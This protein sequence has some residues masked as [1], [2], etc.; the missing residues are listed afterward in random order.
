MEMEPDIDN[1]TMSE[2]LEYEATKEKRLWDDVRSR[3][4]P[5]HY[6]E[7]DFSS[8]HRNKSNT[9]YYPYSHNIPPPPV[10][11]YPKNYLVSTEVSNDVDIENMTIA[12][13]NLYVAKQGLDMN[14]LNNYSKGFTPQFFTQLPYT[15]NTPVFKKDSDLD[16]SCEQDDDLEDDQVEDGDDRDTFDMWDITVEDIERIRQ[17]L[18]PNVPEV[19]EDVIQPLIPKTLHTTPP[20]EDYVA[21]TTKSILDELLEEFGDEIL[22]V[23]M[24]DEGSDF[25]PDKDIEELEK[26]LAND[27]KPYYMEIQVNSVIINPKPFIHTQPMN[28]LYGIFESYKSSTTP[29]KVDRE[30][31]SPF[32][33]CTGGGA[34]ILNKLRGSITNW[35]SWMLY[36]SSLKLLVMLD[37]A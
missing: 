29:Y 34:W 11:S 19:I 33:L 21:P 27:P 5:T 2:Y 1:M 18:T 25:N 3:R 15:P 26:L 17:F 24:V 22:N 32:R 7:A 16:S 9:F 6:D 4:S 28:P 12:E 23:T 31:K 35:T 14:M 13:Y 20:N 37:V 30:M 10:Q 36:R 8:S